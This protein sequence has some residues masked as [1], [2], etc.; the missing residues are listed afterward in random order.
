MKRLMILACACLAAQVLV[1]TDYYVKVG[2]DDTAD[3]KSKATARATVG[4]GVEL[5]AEEGDRLVVCD[6]EYELSGTLSLGAGRKLVS[7]NGRG[8]TSLVVP[9]TVTQQTAFRLFDLTDAASEVRGF[10]IDFNKINYRDVSGA[11]LVYDPAGGTLADCEFRN[12]YTGWGKSMIYLNDSATSLTVTNC[13][14]RNCSTLFRAPIVYLNNTAGAQIANC[15]FTDCSTGIPSS[16]THYLG[17][18]IVFANDADVTVRNCQFVRCRSY[19]DSSLPN[20]LNIL[21]V[22]Q[23]KVAVENCSVIDCEIVGTGLGGAI[24][25][26]GSVCNSFAYRCSG[27][28]GPANLLPGPTYSHCA[29][30]T[31]LAGEGNVLLK[32]GDLTFVNDREE[33]LTVLTGPV[34]DA[35]VNLD[36]MTAGA[37]DLYGSDRVVN[38]VVDIGCSEYKARPAP[39]TYYVSPAGDDSKD[40][41]TRETAKATIAAAV[42]CLSALDERVV[43]TEGVYEKTSAEPLVLSNGWSVVGEGSDKTKIVIKSVGRPFELS[44]RGTRI[45][46]MTFDFG[47]IDFK[48]VASAGFLSD[49]QGVVEN[50]V[51]ENYYT[52]WDHCPVT[53][54]NADVEPV[55][56]NCVFRNCRSAYNDGAAFRIESAKSVLISGCSFLDCVSGDTYSGAGIIYSNVAGTTIRNCLFS[57]CRLYANDTLWMGKPHIVLLKQA[58]S[59][60]ESCSFVNC[61]LWG[62]GTGG[63]V[64]PSGVVRNTYSYRGR[65]AGGWAN[66][67]AGPTYS[68]CASDTELAGEGNILLKS[69]DLEFV[70][71]REGRC[72]VLAGPVIDAGQNLAWMAD[73]TAQ[74]GE[75]RIVNE[76]VDIGCTEYKSRPVVRT[77]YVSPTGDDAK[78]GLT[79]ETAKAT[80][81]A[82]V[83]CLTAPDERVVVTE[84]V[85]ENDSTEPFV[86][87]NGWSVVGESGAAKTRVSI[88]AVGE[89]FLLYSPGSSVRGL[90]FDFNRVD[91]KSLPETHVIGTGKV[92][93]GL[94]VNPQGVIEDCAVE[95]YLTSWG[96]GILVIKDSTISPVIRRCDFRSCRTTYRVP[97]VA[98]EE[99]DEALVDGCSFVDCTA[100][101]SYF[102]YGMI[103]LNTSHATVRNCQ[104]LRCK[105][106][107]NGSDTMG[108]AGIICTR[109]ADSVVENCTILDCEITGTSENGMIAPKGKVTNTLAWRCRNPNG[110]ANLKAGSTTYSHC[111]SDIELA[112]E[113]NVVLTDGCLKLRKVDRVRGVSA[114]LSGPTVDEGKNLYWMEGAADILGWNR[115]CN[116]VVD[117]G[118]SEY[119]PEQVKIPGLVLIVK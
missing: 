25:P 118:C 107:D 73:E 19:D 114:I 74:N 34:I 108:A 72:T 94:T 13:V 8:K 40:G 14:F 98:V 52:S 65:N 30:D 112:G 80:I 16:G 119:D 49:P 113:G 111:A 96:H 20:T 54:K 37:T 60:V 103:F 92:G 85:Y 10:T 51:V 59:V 4:K 27:P 45:A 66:L 1:A 9:T 41:L 53:I 15:S 91:F 7:E 109:A 95:N 17:Y 105:A 3:G 101:T 71:E 84:G 102:C 117:I 76:I 22:T 97:P 36:W 35:G 56:R 18:G 44:T 67:T 50:C 26:K 31:E 12:Y 39:A 5:L 83:A 64:G 70:N 106:Y 100:G 23:A 90:T 61:K 2:G 78:D 21:F 99:A 24:G 6:G 38:D 28:N 55:F 79:R 46:D 93:A 68:Y 48:S 47:N 104:F 110:A 87:S 32:P 62:P 63:A 43:V 11:A 86:L 69:G 116:S 75:A 81:R 115:I 57:G 77:Y 33:R 88:K 89:Q 42:A 82:A 58:K 29:S